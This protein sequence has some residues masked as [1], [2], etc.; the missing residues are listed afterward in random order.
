MGSLI[1]DKTTEARQTDKYDEYSETAF[2]I[3]IFVINNISRF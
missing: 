3:F 1:F 2:Y